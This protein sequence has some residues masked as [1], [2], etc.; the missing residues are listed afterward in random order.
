MCFIY[1][2]LLQ[3]YCRNFCKAFLSG[4][5]FSGLLSG[6]ISALLSA[7]SWMNGLNSLQ[8]SSPAWVMFLQKSTRTSS[9]LS[10]F[11]ATPCRLW[12]V[13]RT[14]FSRRR[15]RSFLHHCST[16]ITSWSVICAQPDSVKVRRFGHL[17]YRQQSVSCFHK[18]V[19]STGGLCR[20][21]I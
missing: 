3:E 14:Q 1:Q 10:P 18:L 17:R 15:L 11:S 20:H 21:H 16:E 7:I 2:K 4:S 19:E 5:F 13:M 9:R 8:L 12:S 6:I